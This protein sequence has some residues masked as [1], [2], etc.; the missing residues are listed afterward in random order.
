MYIA[1]ST[2][3]SPLTPCGHL[4]LPFCQSINQWNWRFFSLRLGPGRMNRVSQVCHSTSTINPQVLR[5]F[6]YDMRITLFFLV[7][8]TLTSITTTHA[9]FTHKL[10]LSLLAYVVFAFGLYYDAH[11]LL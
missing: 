10:C 3:L 8:M 1:P 5:V 9:R 11:E 2:T 7:C 6:F 4:Q